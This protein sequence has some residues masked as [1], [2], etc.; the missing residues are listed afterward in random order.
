MSGDGSLLDKVRERVIDEM[1]YIDGDPPHARV[2]D[3]AETQINAMSNVELLERIG[4]ALESK[5]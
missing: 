5:S 3:W 1:P 4:L 2:W